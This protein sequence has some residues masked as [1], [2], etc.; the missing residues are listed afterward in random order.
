M[1]RLSELEKQ[2]RLRL[3]R[4]QHRRQAR[5]RR[6][7]GNPMVPA[8]L[9][10]PRYLSLDQ[11]FEETLSFLNQLRTFTL[12]SRR[13][14]RLDFR[15]LD[16]VG[17][18]AAIIL[19]AELDY[20]RHAHMITIVLFSHQRRNLAIRVL[21]D[22]LGIF[23]LVKLVNP[24]PLP[25]FSA[26][27]FQFVRFH[28]MPTASGEAASELQRELEGITGAV[29]EWPNLYRALT[30]AMTNVRQHAYP[31]AVSEL[32]ID[33]PHWWMFGAYHQDAKRLVCV[34][35]DRGVGIPAT[36]PRTQS[37]ERL[38]GMLQGLGLGSDDASMIKAA[39]E[40]GRSQTRQEHRGG[41][42]SDV[43][44]VIQRSSRGRLRII[45][46]RGTY[47]FNNDQNEELVNLSSTIGGTLIEWEFDLQQ[48]DQER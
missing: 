18:A 3:A 47:T 36:L 43:K 21:L 24:V 16:Y 4:K 14:L 15:H 22:K 23:D 1:R 48:R 37:I 38:R 5:R 19:A 46:R 8:Y 45:S 7:Y 29:Q 40:L 25:S 30:E 20:R 32:E 31:T 26:L 6:G 10:A 2:K 28:S 13:P 39:T 9:V 33:V 17:P 44:N 27:P 42:L 34:F 41:G 11:S 35:F 12:T